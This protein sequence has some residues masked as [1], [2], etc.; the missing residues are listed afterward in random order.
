M[1]PDDTAK[2]P[3]GNVPLNT[4]NVGVDDTVS[5]PVGN[6]V[7]QVTTEEPESTAV[8]AADQS[9]VGVSEEPIA[10]EPIVTETPSPK[11]SP[12]TSVSEPTAVQPEEPV[13][14]ETN[15]GIGAPSSMGVVEEPP[16]V[17]PVAPKPASTVGDD[18]GATKLRP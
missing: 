12:F 11:T 5:A 13:V 9:S 14:S 3:L 8:N 10:S 17:E 1:D 6:T 4:N 16:A 18:A 2:N 7:P 15:A